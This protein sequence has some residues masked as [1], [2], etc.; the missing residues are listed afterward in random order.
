MEDELRLHV[1]DVV[2]AAAAALLLV[3]AR[4]KEGLIER[5]LRRCHLVGSAVCWPS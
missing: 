5:A 2:G 1:G 4:D 3:F